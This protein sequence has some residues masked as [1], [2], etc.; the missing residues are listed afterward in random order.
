MSE[1]E[2][3]R[4]IF[5]LSDAKNR[6]R[7]G[8]LSHQTVEWM[9]LVTFMR[10]KDF[11]QLL[12]GLVGRQRR[13]MLSP[14]T[15]LREHLSVELQ[16]VSVGI[17]D[18]TKERRHLQGRRPAFE[19]ASREWSTSTV[20]FLCICWWD[21]SPQLSHPIRRRNRGTEAALVLCL[22]TI[23]CIAGTRRPRRLVP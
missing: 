5:Q 19:T 17:G 18:K 2:G 9:F 22:P 21:R 6:E 1:E 8:H 3:G 20:A 11:V 23:W 13:R 14:R 7:N 15:F 12:L 4:R 10:P 16:A